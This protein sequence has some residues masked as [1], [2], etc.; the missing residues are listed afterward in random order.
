M[1]IRCAWCGKFL[2]VS[3]PFCGQRLKLIEHPVSKRKVLVCDTGASQIYFNDISKMPTS[4]GICVECRSR[5]SHGLQNHSVEEFSA[6]DIAN[7]YVQLYGSEKR[8][9]TAVDGERNTPKSSAAQK[10][11]TGHQPAV[12]TAESEENK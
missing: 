10:R 4:H 3:C 12:E 7:L 8:G 1:K 9:P 6:E 5:F 11:G 2:G